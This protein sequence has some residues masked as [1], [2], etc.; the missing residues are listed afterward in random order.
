MNSSN[1]FDKYLFPQSSDPNTALPIKGVVPWKFGVKQGIQLKKIRSSTAYFNKLNA[2]SGTIQTSMGTLTQ[3]VIQ[4][5][6]VNQSLFTGGTLTNSLFSG[7]SVSGAAVLAG[8]EINQI[9]NTGT[10]NTSLFS[11]GTVSGGT[12]DSKYKT[13]GTLGISTTIVYLNAATA[14]GTLTFNNG[15]LILSQ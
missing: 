10:L 3:Y 15:L 11:G 1:G 7:G 4:S 9:F 12:V 8:T 6:T 5:G 2:Q 13:N 14:P